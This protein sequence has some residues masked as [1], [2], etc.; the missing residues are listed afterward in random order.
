MA[1][2]RF[3]TKLLKR[4][5]P[6]VFH[7][8]F[9]LTGEGGTI[10]YDFT[11]E[12]DEAVAAALNQQFGQVLQSEITPRAVATRRYELGFINEVHVTGWQTRRE[13][14]RR[15][16]Q[17][18]PPVRHRRNLDREPAEKT[19]FDEPMSPAPAELVQEP[20]EEP[21]V[22][23]PAVEDNTLAVPA[24]QDHVLNQLAILT[25]MQQQQQQLLCELQQTM[26]LIVG[27]QIRKEERISKDLLS[28]SMKKVAGKIMPPP[29]ML[30]DAGPKNGDAHVDESQR[31]VGP[32]DQKGKS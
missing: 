10:T 24:T 16:K 3:Y 18:K 17:G 1:H 25:R 30:Q 23:A 8:L 31:H 29:I 14:A 22:Q 12:R 5:D 9:H 6:H 13:N 27:G 26:A 20:L 7:S 4:I 32:K 19:L 2:T 28:A 11:Q 15:K 21:A